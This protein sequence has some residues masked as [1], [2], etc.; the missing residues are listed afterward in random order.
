MLGSQARRQLT[1]FDNCCATETGLPAG[2]IETA[3]VGK[4]TGVCVSRDR[5]VTG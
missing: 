1:S 3:W 4:E 5:R 2:D